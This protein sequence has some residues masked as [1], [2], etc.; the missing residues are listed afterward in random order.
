MGY[1]FFSLSAV[2]GIITSECQ[3]G[4]RFCGICGHVAKPPSNS[5][6]RAAYQVDAT[7]NMVAD[8]S[9]LCSVE[10]KHC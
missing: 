2:G 5:P 8:I 4:K 3:L 9:H 7:L 1:L 6:R 10:Q